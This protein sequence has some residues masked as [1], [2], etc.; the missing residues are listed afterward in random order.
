MDYERLG[1]TVD[2]FSKKLEG[3]WT[4]EMLELS[5]ALSDALMDIP[6]MSISRDPHCQNMFHIGIENNRELS[7]DGSYELVKYMKPIQVEISYDHNVNTF[8]YIIRRGDEHYINATRIIGSIE[9][10]VHTI[11]GIYQ[12]RY[13]NME[14]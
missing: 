4:P 9:L 13:E 1:K 3:K 6:G 10:A 7:D 8:E 11:L 5:T 2:S 14:R 12:D